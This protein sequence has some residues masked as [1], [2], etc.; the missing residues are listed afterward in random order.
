MMLILH[1]YTMSNK[2]PKTNIGIQLEDQKSK[3]AVP[4]TEL[5]ILPPKTVRMRLSIRTVSSYLIYLS[6]A[7]IKGTHCHCPASRV[8]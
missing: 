6:R 1:M 3:E 4:Q 5:V 8:N 2:N 7:E